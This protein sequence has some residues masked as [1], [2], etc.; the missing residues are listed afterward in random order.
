MV[1]Q[2]ER[3]GETKRPH[4]QGAIWLTNGKALGAMKQIEGLEKAHFA[5]A[6]G[7]WTQNVAYCSK[8]CSD[9][10]QEECKHEPACRIAGP[11]LLGQEESKQGK[12]TNVAT[13]A[14]QAEKLS[15]EGKS[16]QEIIEAL[17]SNEE[18]KTTMI[19][20]PVGMGLH[21]AVHVGKQ[22]HR[23]RKTSIR[24]VTGPS[25]IGKS[26]APRHQGVPFYSLIWTNKD[27]WWNG[28]VGQPII[29]IDDFNPMKC[30]IPIDVWKQWLDTAGGVQVQVKHSQAYLHDAIWWFTSNISWNNWPDEWRTG[31]MG[32]RMTELMDEGYPLVYKDD[33]GDFYKARRVPPIDISKE[34]RER[35]ETRRKRILERDLAA[36]EQEPEVQAE[37]AP[38][39]KEP[40]QERPRKKKTTMTMMMEDVEIP[41]R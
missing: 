5:A 28:Y 31:P 40:E 38:P 39:R 1:W 8:P 35:R 20:H 10:E 16:H 4:V 37:R 14:E 2:V 3:C 34:A 26:Y 13:T 29:I 41:E 15:K 19:K 11:W 9:R 17:H 12:K 36:G 21:I 32:R 6:K 25:G 18:T 30:A 23:D 22:I 27:T 7:T 33:A 24:V